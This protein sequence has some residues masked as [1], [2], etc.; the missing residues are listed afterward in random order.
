MPKWEQFEINAAKYLTTNITVD[1]ISFKARGSH[2]S[3]ASDIIVSLNN[4]LI[5]TI[6]CKFSPA[7]SSQFV[8]INK[9]G[10]FSISTKSR[11]TPDGTQEIIAHM[12]ANSDYY[13]SQD[14]SIPLLCCRELMYSRIVQQ[15][16]KKSPLFISS[17]VIENFCPDNP[18]ILDRVD[19]ISSYFDVS[20]V[21]RVKQSGTREPAKKDLDLIREF[22]HKKKIKI[23]EKHPKCYIQDPKATISQYFLENKFFLQDPIDGNR[24]IRKISGTRNKNVIF[25]LKLKE[26][27]VHTG[28]QILT[29]AINDSTKKTISF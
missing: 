5:F 7:Q 1:G 3:T 23:T 25:T 18:L 22:F 27:L 15:I 13:S 2:D 8:V 26:G 19:K 24:E 29:D 12:N 28:L 10:R 16:R 4:K 21:Y 6:E 9:N 20:G 17:S 14:E 11:N